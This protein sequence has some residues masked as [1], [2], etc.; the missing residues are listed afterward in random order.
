MGGPTLAPFH[1]NKG[2]LKI[3]K[4]A[5]LSGD[6]RLGRF[7]CLRAPHEPRRHGCCACPCWLR[8]V[9]PRSHSLSQRE[10]PLALLSISWIKAE[11]TP[12]GHGQPCAGPR[13]GLPSTL[14]RVFPWRV[15]RRPSSP[16][17]TVLP[18]G[19]KQKVGSSSFQNSE[20]EPMPFP[21]MSTRRLLTT[22]LL[23]SMVAGGHRKERAARTRG[24]SW[25]GITPEQVYR[26]SLKLPRHSAWNSLVT[27]G[28]LFN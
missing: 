2:K 3:V 9:D 10:G 14:R 20:V 12:V 23:I 26:D 17:P 4:E 8:W 5:F 19:W 18:E 25:L 13:G 11:V 7:I 1:Q 24:R 15:A 16:G 27:F 28:D 21:R 6:K 22:E